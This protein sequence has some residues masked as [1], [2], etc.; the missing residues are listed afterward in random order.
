[1]D[2]SGRAVADYATIETD[3]LRALARVV[4]RALGLLL[5]YWAQTLP[6]THPYRQAARMVESYL[7]TRY[8]V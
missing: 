6:A 3:E 1:M 7:R 8:D 5:A 4:R 2:D